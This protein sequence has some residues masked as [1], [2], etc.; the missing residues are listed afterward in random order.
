MLLVAS[1]LLVGGSIAATAGYGLR[2]RSSAHRLQTQQ[3]LSAFLNL[4]CDIGEIRPLTFSSRAFD[5]VEVHLADRR[6]RVFQCAQAVWHERGPAAQRVNDLDLFDGTLAV[7]ADRWQR[8]D[9]AQVLRSGLEHDFE[10]IRLGEVRL[11]DF[12]LE[13]RQGLLRLTCARA[14]GVV[15]FAGDAAGTA[16]LAAPVINGYTTVEPA[17]IS[18][19]FSPRAVRTAGV[20]ELVLAV[21]TVPLRV[22]GIDAL[23]PAPTTR[24][25]FAGRIEYRA[26]AEAPQLSLAGRLEDASLAELTGGLASGP[27]RGTLDVAIDEA[28]VVDRTVTRLIGRGEIHAL[29]LRDLS[30]LFNQPLDGTADL[31]VGMADVA[32]GHV[33]RLIVDGVAEEVSLEPL[34]ALFGQSRITGSLRIQINA[35]RIRNDRIEWADVEVQALPPAGQKEGTIG[36]KLLLNGLEKGLAFQWPESVSPEVLPERIAYTR[37]EMRLLVRDNRLRVLGTH[38]LRNNTILTIR[39]LGTEVGVVRTLSH[40]IDLTPHILRLRESLARRDPHELEQWWRR[41]AHPAVGT[42]PDKPP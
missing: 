19:T 34:S 6:A 23:L 13:Y 27:I 42:N 26:G 1:L 14:E 10:A 8:E 29:K 32:L 20:R 25:R 18:A 3:R 35:L 36:R 4:P 17:L 5:R 7:S 2:L 28:R 21:P 15:T 22:L 33:N 38:G 11:H 31:N 39:I 24:G 41:R 40:E 37:L 16:R 9:Y 12:R 30:A